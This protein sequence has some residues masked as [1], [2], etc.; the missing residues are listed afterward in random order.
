MH[1][2]RFENRKREHIIQSLDSAHQAQ[3]LSGLARVHLVHE[4]LP[5]LDFHETDL[6]S[7]CLG[8]PARTP[9]YVAGMTAGHDG[10]AHLNRTLALACQRRG[11][12][13]GVGSQRRQLG[14]SET[15]PISDTEIP[16]AT[17]AKTD[18]IDQWKKLRDEV[19]K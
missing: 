11:W 14:T 12:A 5:D 13:M 4:A 6:N 16:V 7:P 9:F 10:A 1:I 3:G 15:S 18:Q 8:L 2:E 17:L 19:P